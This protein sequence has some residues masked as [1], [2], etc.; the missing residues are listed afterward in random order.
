[1]QTIM[2]IIQNTLR[3]TNYKKYLIYD[4]EIK[5]ETTRYFSYRYAQKNGANL[6]PFL[7]SVIR[8][9]QKFTFKIIDQSHNVLIFQEKERNYFHLFQIGFEL[10][11][12]NKGVRVESKW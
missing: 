3:C 8:W 7:K 9:K 10:F 1:M 4:N 2:N 6:S 5:K 12:I 11:T